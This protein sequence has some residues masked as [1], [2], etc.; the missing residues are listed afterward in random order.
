MCK[1]LS[2][3]TLSTCRCE[4]RYNWN[5]LLDKPATLITRC[6]DVYRDVSDCA[7]MCQMYKRSEL[8]TADSVESVFGQLEK[9]RHNCRYFFNETT[10]NIC[11]CELTGPRGCVDFDYETEYRK[12]LFQLSTLLKSPFILTIGFILVAIFFYY[13]LAYGKSEGTMCAVI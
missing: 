5:E 1:Y 9:W 2:N 10:V 12:Y 6:N 3:N 4:S 11:G 8:T 7:D 13:F